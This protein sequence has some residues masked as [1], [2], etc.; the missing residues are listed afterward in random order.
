M[1]DAEKK[2]PQYEWGAPEGKTR[3]C[4]TGSREPLELGKQGKGVQNT[5]WKYDNVLYPALMWYWSEITWVEEQQGEVSWAEVA[6]DFQAATHT[7][8]SRDAMHGT[9][10]P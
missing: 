7:G 2:I 1:V 5:V 10:K 6:L 8:L 3:N 4:F 9:L